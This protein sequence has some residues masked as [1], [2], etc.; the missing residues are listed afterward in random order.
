MVTA[1]AVGVATVAGGRPGDAIVAGGDEDGG[2]CVGKVVL[3][4]WWV[5]KGDGDGT[6]GGGRYLGDRVS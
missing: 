4:M 2:A 3:E 5:D 6:G 1:E